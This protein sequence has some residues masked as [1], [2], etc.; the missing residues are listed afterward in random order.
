MKKLLTV[1]SFLLIGICGFFGIAA[2]DPQD[3]EGSKDPPHFNRMPGYYINEYEEK[4]FDGVEFKTG[5]EKS[6]IIEGHHFRLRYC[7]KEDAKTAGPVQIVWN[8]S[9]AVKT[10]G[11]QVVYATGDEATLKLVAQDAETWV[12]ISVYNNGDIY[13]LNIVERQLMKQ[14]VVTDAASLAQSIKNE[15]KAEIFEI[16]FDTG[17][18]VIKPEEEP[19]LRQIAKLFQV[20]PKLKLYVVGHTDKVGG[21]D[22]NLNLARER[23]EAVA[24]ALTE[25][26]FVDAARL[27]AFVIGP[28]AP[29]ESNRTEEGPSQEP[30]GG[31][32]GG[33]I[34]I[35]TG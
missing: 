32:G 17:K 27:R 2:A 16:Y 26:Y 34:I 5:A 22:D 24:K 18:S 1:V 30:A 20:S 9:N 3:C 28:R 11:G 4:E 21:I 19:A 23:A 10:S 6:G 14:V 8:Y 15:E 25:K 31:A 35:I 29:V 13:E 7:V 33:V 12:Y